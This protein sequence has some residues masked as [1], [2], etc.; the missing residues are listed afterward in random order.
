VKLNK[1][2]LLYGS[3]VLTL[4]ATAWL[5]SKQTANSE[6]IESVSLETSTSRLDERGF[7]NNGDPA[8][9]TP[10][11][12]TRKPILRN[13]AAVTSP[14]AQPVITETHQ[15]VNLFAVPEVAQDEAPPEN[16]DLI[17]DTPAPPPAPAL[18]FVY[19][20]KFEDKSGLLVYLMENEVLLTVAQGEQIDERYRLTAISDQ[21]LTFHYRPLNIQQ[22]LY[23][24]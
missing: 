22:T 21:Q 3:L 10:G 6:V 13:A 11:N 18:P 24:K 8:S 5:S 15:E 19:L 20:G 1:S 17:L 4:I 12:Q 2:L 9:P 16:T 23:I 14:I 7:S